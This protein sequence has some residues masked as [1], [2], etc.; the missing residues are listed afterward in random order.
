MQLL[1]CWTCLKQRPIMM[2]QADPSS[3]CSL[4]IW[5]QFKGEEPGVKLLGGDTCYGCECH[6]QAKAKCFRRV[7][8]NVQLVQCKNFPCFKYNTTAIA[9]V[10]YLQ[11]I[12]ENVIYS[13]WFL[14]ETE[15][16]ELL[17]SMHY[18][19]YSVV[20]WNTCIAY[21]YALQV[22]LSVLV[23]LKKN[24]HSNLFYHISHGLREGFIFVSKFASP[25]T[26]IFQALT[27]SVNILKLD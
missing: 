20:C 23:Q 6:R 9:V 22:I 12:Y 25:A 26:V 1:K 15:K 21:M 18:K 14:S 11:C 4:S 10:V 13:S 7:T 17:F 5:T 3:I 24:L 16:Y 2:V 27:L 8:P 19:N